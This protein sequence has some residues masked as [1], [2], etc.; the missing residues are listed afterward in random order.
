MPAARPIPSSL[1]AF[2]NRPVIRARSRAG[3]IMHRAFMSCLVAALAGCASRPEKPA[4]PKEPPA[5]PVKILQFYAGAGVV[6][7]GQS[8]TICYGVE[9]ARAVRIEPPVEEVKPAFNRCFA[10]TPSASTTYR[11]IAEGADGKEAT[12]SFTVRVRGGAAQR[13]ALISIFSASSEEIAPGETV[14]LCYVAADALAL[15]LE[16]N[17]RPV[18]PGRR[19][20]ALQPAKTTR[21]RLTATGEGGARESRSVTITVK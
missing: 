19:C 17:V 8:V 11:L 2:P 3:S 21:Y 10:A 1:G 13:S 15:K 4:A 9:N 14:T 12:A 5:A 16:P 6:D 18:E 7:A 20:F